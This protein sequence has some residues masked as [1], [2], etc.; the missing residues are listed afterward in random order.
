MLRL[1]AQLSLVRFGNGG[2]PLGVYFGYPIRTAKIVPLMP[3]P[4]ALGLC[5]T[6]VLK[7]RFE[8]GW[9]SRRQAC[10]GTPVFGG[11]AEDQKGHALSDCLVLFD[12]AVSPSGNVQRR[13][14]RS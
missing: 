10:R 1:V 9:G 7:K 14:D 6:T 4:E 11:K 5:S 2:R 12:M 13:T 3:R 8:L